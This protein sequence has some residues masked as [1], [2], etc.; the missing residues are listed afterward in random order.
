MYVYCTYTHIIEI[1]QQGF[2]C[3]EE[4]QCASHT[5]CAQVLQ[6]P[7]SHFVDNREGTLFSMIIYALC[8]SCF[9]EI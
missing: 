8:P 3:N 1:C 9:C 7:Q 4:P 5:S 6:L 2:I